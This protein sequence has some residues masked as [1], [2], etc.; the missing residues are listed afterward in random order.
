MGHEFIFL[1]FFLRFWSLFE[2]LLQVADE[3][4][5]I[6]PLFMQQSKIPVLLGESLQGR[7]V[8]REENGFEVFGG[9]NQSSRGLPNFAHEEHLLSED[10]L[11]EQS[12]HSLVS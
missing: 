11:N 5:V 4:F 2:L 1:L 3:L 6:F 8:V 9:I 12:P 10:F 7:S